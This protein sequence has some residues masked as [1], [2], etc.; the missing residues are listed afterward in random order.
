[1]LAQLL[2]LNGASHITLAA[3]PGPKLD[4]AQQL[5]VADTYVELSRIEPEPQYERIK[6]DHSHGFDIVIEA[7]GSVKVLQEAIHFC[8][9][10]GTLVVY[11]FVHPLSPFFS[12]IRL[13]VLPSWYWGRV[14]SMAYVGWDPTD[15]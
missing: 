7:T 5:G 4:V 12:L 15:G 6:A 1:M 2:R 8:R 13:R 10:G 11:G 14:S 9:R 3:P